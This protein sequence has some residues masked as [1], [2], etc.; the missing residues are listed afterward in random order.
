MDKME[1]MEMNITTVT[2]VTC[3]CPNEEKKNK[4]RKLT[5]SCISHGKPFISTMDIRDSDV[6]NELEQTIN[7]IIY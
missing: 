4:K 3:L 5:D 7:S 6:F 1:F 2:I